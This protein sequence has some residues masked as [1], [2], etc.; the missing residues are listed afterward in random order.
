MLLTRVSGPRCR[1]QQRVLGQE[2]PD[3]LNSMGN[4]ASTFRD[5]GR[6]KEAEELQVQVMETRNRVLGQEHPSTL[7][8]IDNLAWIWKSQSRNTEALK[9]LFR[10]VELSTEKLAP[11]MFKTWM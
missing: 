7:N 8:S 4:L 6:W 10:C 9:S 3:T 5:Q 1:F 11:I 2:H